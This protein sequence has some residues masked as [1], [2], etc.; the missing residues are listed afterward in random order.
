MLNVESSAAKNIAIADLGASQNI[1]RSML[2]SYAACH[3][4][5]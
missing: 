3:M 4:I 5:T 1:D 2:Q